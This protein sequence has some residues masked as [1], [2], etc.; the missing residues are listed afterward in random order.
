MG[1]IFDSRG[2]APAARLCP[3]CRRF[4]IRASQGCMVSS[5]GNRLTAAIG[6][7]ESLAQRPTR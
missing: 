5:M 6:R 3:A 4:V 2:I 7:R 1:T